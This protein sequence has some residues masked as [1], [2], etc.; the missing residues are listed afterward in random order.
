MWPA[1]DSSQTRCPLVSSFMRLGERSPLAALDDSGV[2]PRSLWN[3]V[4]PPD[5]CQPEQK[6]ELQTVDCLY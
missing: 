2:S 1:V 5:V 6:N 4:V 3:S